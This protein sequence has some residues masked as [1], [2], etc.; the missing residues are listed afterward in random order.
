M[1]NDARHP[2]II[3]WRAWLPRS[4]AGAVLVLALAP[5]VYA[6]DPALRFQLTLAGTVPVSTAIA[7]AGG[8]SSAYICAPASVTSTWPAGSVIVPP[9]TTGRPFGETWHVPPGTRVNYHFDLT[10]CVDTACSSTTPIRTI[11]TGELTMGGTDRTVNVA[12]TF[13]AMPNTSTAERMPSPRD[14]SLPVWILVLG[15]LLGSAIGVRR[16]GRRA[17]TIGGG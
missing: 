16:F 2:R 10:Y 4:V 12:L 11:W 17:P 6:D 8:S 5:P 14:H 1:T 15:S 3:S 7:L 13:G 9:C